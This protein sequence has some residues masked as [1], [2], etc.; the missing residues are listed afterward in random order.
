[1]LEFFADQQ[2]QMGTNQERALLT[3]LCKQLGLDPA[4]GYV[5]HAGLMTEIIRRLLE[6]EKRL[7]INGHQ[8]NPPQGG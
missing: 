2:R 6:I 4:K 7:E 5:S 1:M 3:D 8:G